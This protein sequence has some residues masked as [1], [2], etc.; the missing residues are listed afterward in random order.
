MIAAKN[1]DTLVVSRETSYIALI[2]Q[3]MALVWL[4]AGFFWKR[5]KNGK[6]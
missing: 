6:A 5:T 3:K 4:L 1:G 2:M